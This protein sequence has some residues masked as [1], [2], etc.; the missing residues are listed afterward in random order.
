M[1]RINKRYLKRL[2]LAEK[3]KIGK[4]LLLA[5]AMGKAKKRVNILLTHYINHSKN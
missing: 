4:H 3:Q 1:K 5:K 2:S